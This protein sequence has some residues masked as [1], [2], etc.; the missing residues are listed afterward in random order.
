MPTE[1]ELRAMTMA[2]LLD[3]DLWSCDSWQASNWLGRPQLYNDS[4]SLLSVT[5]SSNR[6][7]EP[8]LR[9]VQDNGLVRMVWGI[10][11]RHHAVIVDTF[12]HGGQMSRFVDLVQS[13][14]FTDRADGLRWPA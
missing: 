3:Q 1:A 5:V 8:V 14:K 9:I 11:T 12:R 10:P 2:E 7:G 6:A 13:L 4:E